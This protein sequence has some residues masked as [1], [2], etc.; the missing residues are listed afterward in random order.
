MKEKTIFRLII[1]LAI[2]MAVINVTLFISEYWCHGFIRTVMISFWNNPKSM[3]LTS[4]IHAEYLIVHFCIIPVFRVHYFAS[5][6]S[7]GHYTCFFFGI[8]R[9]YCSF[10]SLFS[11]YLLTQL[12]HSAITLSWQLAKCYRILFHTYDQEVIEYGLYRWPRAHK[13]TDT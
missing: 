6:R 4:K 3:V 13:S 10:F 1:I 7:I 11:Q 5:W 12:K 2:L 8:Y 9:L